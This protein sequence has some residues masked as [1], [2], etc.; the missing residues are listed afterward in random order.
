MNSNYLRVTNISSLGSVLDYLKKLK[1]LEDVVVFFDWDD[2]LVNPDYD[3]IIEPETTKELFDYMRNNKIFFSIITGR[4]HDSACDDY[5]RNIFVMQKNIIDTMY[6]SINKLGI[7]TSKYHTDQFKQNIHKITD[8]KG[9]CVGVL[10]MGIFFSG[11][12]GAAIK[13]YLRQMGMN[14]RE[15]VFVDD[16]EPYLY[17]TTTALPYVTAFRRLV[18]YIPLK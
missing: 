16:Y 13:H 4:F 1:N 18:N 14:K 5:K 10:Y 15:V 12:K 3:S 6:P 9:N 2:T 7:D 11:T 17:E 8:E